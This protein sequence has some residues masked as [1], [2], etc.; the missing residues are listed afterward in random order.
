[1][2]IENSQFNLL[3]KKILVTG[4]SSGIGKA[5]AI[6]ASELGAKVVVCGRN[7][8]RVQETLDS[9][10][11]PD[12]SCFVGDLT[13]VDVIQTLVDGVSELDGVVF[14]AGEARTLPFLFSDQNAFQDVF[15]INFFSP[16]ELLRLLAKTKAL[17]N[18]ASVVFIS[19]LASGNKLAVGNTVYG[20]SKAAVNSVVQYAALELSAQKIRVN[21]ICPGV[22]NTPMVGGHNDKLKELVLGNQVK[23]CPLKRLGEPEDIANMAV[24]L[25]SDASSWVTGQTICVDGG[26]SLV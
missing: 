17:K 14:S 15:N 2:G 3:G 21:A 20:T 1:M 5:C 12:H 8:A 18:S 13:K 16:T 10:R 4:A 24:F 7:E 9:L 26:S 6:R 23:N 19:S 25:L 11:G 22:V